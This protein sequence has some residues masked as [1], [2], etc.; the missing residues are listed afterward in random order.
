MSEPAATAEAEIVG[1]VSYDTSDPAVVNNARKKAGRQKREE[2]S[3]VGALMETRQGRGWLYGMLE[4][5]HIFQPSFVP[6]D[7]HQ[8]AFREGERNVG[9]MILAD[10]QASAPQ[11]YT[12][13]VDEGRPRGNA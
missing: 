5:T 8:T 11:L 6:G 13:M 10:I 1:G 3:V 4:R 9:L 12:V 2:L 7:T